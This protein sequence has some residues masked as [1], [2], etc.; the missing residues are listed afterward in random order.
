MWHWCSY[1]ILTSSVIYY[2]TD[3]WQHGIYLF[4]IIKKQT[5]TALLFQNLFQLL[6]SRRPLPTLVDMKKAIWHNLLSIQNETIP[7]VAMHSKE[8]W[9]VQKNHANIKLHSNW[10]LKEWKLT[11]KSELWNLQILEKMLEKSN[12]FLL[13]CK[14]KSLD[15]EGVERIC[16]EN[17]RLRSTMEACFDYGSMVG[18]PQISLI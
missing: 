2:W 9:L 14:P 15:I 3:A 10:F 6:E 11:A 13:S 18:D 1:H 8:L 17:L 7:L 4:Y 16:S 12:Q 5:T